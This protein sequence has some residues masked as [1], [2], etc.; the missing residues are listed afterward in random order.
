MKPGLLACCC[1]AAWL[2]VLS[3]LGLIVFAAPILVACL[4][5]AVINDRPEKN[6]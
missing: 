3:A 4:V 1:S 2:G 5:L 6:T